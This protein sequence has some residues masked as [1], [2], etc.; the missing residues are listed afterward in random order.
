ML[1]ID[2]RNT[3][4]FIQAHI[5]DSV[6][7][8][9]AEGNFEYWF[10]QVVSDPTTQ[11]RLVTELNK[12]NEICRK[13]REMNY[14]GFTVVDDSSLFTQR[15]TNIKPTDLKKKLKQCRIL[16]VRERAETQKIK[17]VRSQNMPLSEILNGKNPKPDLEYYVHCAGGYR[18]LIA[19]SWINHSKPYNLINIQGGLE[20]LRATLQEDLFVISHQEF[21]K[22]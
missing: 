20:A 21:D 18:S 10:K 5:S 15:T 12:R 11:F 1:T 17:L 8:G 22:K 3:E 7:V 6:F 13:L 19:I 16:D 4:Y 14:E 9:Y 2:T